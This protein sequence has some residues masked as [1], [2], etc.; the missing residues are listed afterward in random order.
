MLTAALMQPGSFLFT[1]TF[2]EGM[3]SSYAHMRVH[4]LKGLA[5][6]SRITPVSSPL[7]ERRSHRLCAT[8]AAASVLFAH[9]FVR[10]HIENTSCIWRLCVV[11]V[12]TPD[13]RYFVFVRVQVNVL[14]DSVLFI[15]GL[16]ILLNSPN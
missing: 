13:S 11:I 5:F 3:F 12:C 2:S 7:E 9:A 14:V 8:L 10:C 15:V 16:L 6:R 1:L 4:A